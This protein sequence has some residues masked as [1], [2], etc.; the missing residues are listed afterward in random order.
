MGEK[1]R[2]AHNMLHSESVPVPDASSLESLVPLPPAESIDALSP[3]RSE[4]VMSDPG[5]LDPDA[6]DGGNIDHRSM[7][8]RARSAPHSLTHA[9][10]LEI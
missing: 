10:A 2:P 8:E 7:A 4:T 5:D 6:A 1:G 3:L 9:N